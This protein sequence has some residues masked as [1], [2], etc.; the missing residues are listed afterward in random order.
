MNGETTGVAKTVVTVVNVI[1]TKLIIR[2]TVGVKIQMVDSE[3]GGTI[4]A[5][6]ETKKTSDMTTKTQAVR[7]ETTIEVAVA[8]TTGDDDTTAWMPTKN[9]PR[10]R[11]L[12]PVRTTN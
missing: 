4:D 12:P 3:G 6:E 10:P 7:R 11:R 2:N 9:T 5:I 8:T 1:P